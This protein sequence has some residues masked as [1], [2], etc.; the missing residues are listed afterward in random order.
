MAGLLDLCWVLQCGSRVWPL[1]SNLISGSGAPLFAP[2]C[3]SLSVR[4]VASRPPSP[5]RRLACIPDRLCALWAG[6][7]AGP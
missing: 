7:L 1:G 3:P 4:P 6:A 5:P 2:P